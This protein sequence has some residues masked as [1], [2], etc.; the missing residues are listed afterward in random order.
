MKKSLVVHITVMV[1]AVVLGSGLASYLM[2]QQSEISVNRD[3]LSKAPLGGF[4]KFAS[5]VQWMLFI[6][7]AGIAD[8]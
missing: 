7:Y 2:M 8:C 5:D 4:N 1:I 3:K 6:N